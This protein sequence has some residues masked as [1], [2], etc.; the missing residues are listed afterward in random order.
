MEALIFMGIQ[1]TGKSTFY[2]EHFYKTH[3]RINLDMLKTRNRE[4]ILFKACLDMKQSF[5]IDNTNPTIEDRN[6]YIPATKEYKFRPIGYFFQSK[7][8]DS[9][10]RN[11]TRNGSKTS[12]RLRVG[13]SHFPVFAKRHAG[14]IALNDLS[15]FLFIPKTVI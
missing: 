11:L 14:F 15:V 3:L 9:L 10:E 5:V 2:L 12:Q 7:I 6:R 8:S 4:K 1:A 13:P